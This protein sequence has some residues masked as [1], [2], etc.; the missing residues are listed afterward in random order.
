MLNTTHIKI[1]FILMLRLYFNLIRPLIHYS[2]QQVINTEYADYT[3]TQAGK[4][5]L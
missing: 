3:M 2:N 1:R 4:M 5:Y